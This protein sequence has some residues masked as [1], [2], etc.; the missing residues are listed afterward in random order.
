MKLRHQLGSWAN[1]KLKYEF[2]KKYMKK[3]SAKL[4][5]E[6]MKYTIYPSSENVF[7]A[8]RLT[9]PH[10]IK[11]VILGQDPYPHEAA[12]GLAFSANESFEDNPASLNNI[13]REVEDDI[14]FQPYHNPDLERWSKQ[15]VF[16]LNTALTVREDQPGSHSNIG[17]KR[18]TKKTL[19]VIY[20]KE[21][22][23]VFLLWGREAQY[24][25]AQIPAPHHVI[26]SAH[27]SVYSAHRGFYGS[28]PF[29]RTNEFLEANNFEPIDWLEN[30][31]EE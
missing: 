5:V 10:N 1:T 31:Y 6:R 3:L 22:P 26:F 13:F 19:E 18:F 14:G 16:L 11:V 15:G 20:E 2:Q 7:R 4:R 25:G 9:P 29:S 23:V 24:Y 12:N 28:K 30:D 21:E 27:P 8:Y 17:W